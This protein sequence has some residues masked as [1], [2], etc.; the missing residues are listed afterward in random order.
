MNISDLELICNRFQ[1]GSL[2]SGPIRVYGSR[3]GSLLWRINTNNG[4]YVIKQLAPC[5]DMT[6]K[7]MVAKYE[8]SERIAQEFSLQAIPTVVA[9]DESGNHLILIDKTG[10]LVYPWIEGKTLKQ[11]EVSEPRALKIAELLAKIHSIN[12]NLPEVGPPHF[13]I[14]SN[15]QIDEAI[16]KAISVK[17]SFIS[18]L[19]DSKNLVF[20]MNDHYH[21]AIPILREDAIIT[22]GDLDQLNVIWDK[23]GTPFLV[24]WESARRMNATREIVRTSLNW[25]GFETEQFQIPLYLKMLQ[26]YN[27]ACGLLKISHIESALYG[28]VGSMVFWMRYNID[29]ACTSSD[30]AI[31][32]ISVNEV[33]GVLKTFARLNKLLPELLNSTVQACTK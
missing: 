29:L 30:P 28:T 6:N 10:Y 7:R 27:N 3:G 5:L 11:N 4:S 2:K 31:Q 32:N 12:L 8:M 24:D 14:Y 33:N 1:L 18:Q 15:D 26:T 19:I 9:L 13:D 16:E 25:S 20:S 22:H 21:S 23:D 17:C